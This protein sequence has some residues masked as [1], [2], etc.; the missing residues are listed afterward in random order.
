VK[1]LKIAV[2]TGDKIIHD[3]SITQY[4]EKSIKWLEEEG[5]TVEKIDMQHFE[6]ALSV[7]YVITPCEA[8]SNLARYDGII[9]DTPGSGDTYQERCMSARELFG[10][11]VKRRIL[12]GTYLTSNEMYEKYYLQAQK[13]R[14][15]VKNEF[16]QTFE[17]YDLILTPTTP[18]TA[19]PIDEKKTPVEMY[20]EDYFT[21]P[22]NISGD[23]AISV[24]VG[25]SEQTNMPIGMQ[26]IAPAFQENLL[27]EAG[28]MLEKKAQFKPLE[29]NKIISN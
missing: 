5:A 22:V 13:I 10:D 21:C 15:L 26:I 27:V 8:A 18:H 6:E 2:I 3:K 4:L 19:F 12:V 16:A 29:P 20:Y 9:Y 24:P 7:Y 23:C 28:L 1:G 17:K 25:Y 14:Q 11:E